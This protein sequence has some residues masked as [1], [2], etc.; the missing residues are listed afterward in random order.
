[1][2]KGISV[3]LISLDDRHMRC[4]M[5]ILPDLC[6]FLRNFASLD[7]PYPEHSV[8]MCTYL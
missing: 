4:M 7:T 3:Y 2:E 6:N 8:H 1:M 5:Y